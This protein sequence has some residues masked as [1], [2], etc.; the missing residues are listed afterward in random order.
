MEI[1]NCSIELLL[2]KDELV[3]VGL[4]VFF[5]VHLL[6]AILFILSLFFKPSSSAPPAFFQKVV[7]FWCHSLQS[8]NES[9]K[10][11]LSEFCALDISEGNLS[12]IYLQ[13][14]MCYI[15]RL[16]GSSSSFSCLNLSLSK[17]WW[18]I[19]KMTIVQKQSFGTL[20]F[21]CNPSS[22]FRNEWTFTV[23]LIQSWGKRQDVML[24]TGYQA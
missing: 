3:F 24:G 22:D 16:L 5:P 13:N 2:L 11:L 7:S 15:V 19:I 10:M 8:F 4:L 21:Y 23:A 14:E 9:I 18:E 20:I 6:L 12:L 17:S 1:I